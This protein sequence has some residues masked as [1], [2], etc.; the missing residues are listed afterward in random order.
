MEK[1]NNQMSTINTIAGGWTP[2]HELT[3]NDQKV[4]KEAMNGFVGVDYTPYLVS[5]QV[6][7]GTNYRYKC[8]ASNP[9]AEVM[10]EAI[11]QIYAP[12]NG[13]PYVTHIQPL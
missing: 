1:T 7:N 10:W 5:T 12:T 2:Y 6:V 13:K 9:P 11:V 4:F 8:S 3:A